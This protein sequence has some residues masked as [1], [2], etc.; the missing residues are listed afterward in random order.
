MNGEDG[1]GGRRLCE[2]DFE[3]KKEEDFMHIVEFSVRSDPFI[4]A[5][6][7]CTIVFGKVKLD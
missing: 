7:Q 1:S 3:G 2:N 4:E 6:S 5:R